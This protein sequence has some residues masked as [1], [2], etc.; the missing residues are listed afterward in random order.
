MYTPPHFAEDRSGILEELMR[1]H[2]L[3]T[4]V[5]G[6]G[7][8]FEATHI[9][10]LLDGNI[11]RGHVARANPIA[12]AAGKRALAIF[13]GSEHYAAIERFAALPGSRVVHLFHNRHELTW[14]RRPD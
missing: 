7:D 9:P 4:L 14:L 5:I 12:N 6:S 11:L 13:Q 3:A 2:P 10:F 8:G 1:E